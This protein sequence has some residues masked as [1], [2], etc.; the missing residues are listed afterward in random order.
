MKL[1]KSFV[2]MGSVDPVVCALLAAGAPGITISHVHG[3]G[4]E[5]DPD[6]S[7]FAPGVE[8]KAPE[9]ASIEVVC[10]EEAAD[11]LLQTIVE[12]AGS[13]LRGDGIVFISSVER[14]VK[15]RNRAEGPAV[16]A[17]GS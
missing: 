1:V 13:G 14:V 8:G 9:V 17:G 6:E 7:T 12:A 4:Y 11:E 2:R 16:L 15:I 3:I 10:R 5:Y